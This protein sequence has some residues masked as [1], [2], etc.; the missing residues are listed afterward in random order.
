MRRQIIP[1]LLNFDYDIGLSGAGQIENATI[2]VDVILNT[3]IKRNDRWGV[4][5]GTTSIYNTYIKRNETFQA[6]I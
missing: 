6:P 1:I 5:I 3:L 2:D 4:T